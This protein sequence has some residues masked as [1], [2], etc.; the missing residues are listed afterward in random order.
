M[1][2]TSVEKFRCN[3]LTTCCF[4]GHRNRDLPFNGNMHKQGVKNLVSTL[5]LLIVE[6]ISDGYDTFISGMADGIDLICADIVMQLKAS[7]RSPDIK[8]VCALPYSEQF[9]EIVSTLDKYKYTLILRDC[10]E[11]VIVSH[12][13]DPDRYKLRNAFMIENSSRLIGAIKN[14]QRGSGTL[15]TLNMAKRAGLEIHMISLDKNPQMK[16]D[17]DEGNNPERTLPITGDMKKPPM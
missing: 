2:E 8:L 4:T 15:Q 1:K 9:G 5:Q 12:R 3:K 13:D 14:K 11:K 7:G 6:A 17:L 10:D 16:I